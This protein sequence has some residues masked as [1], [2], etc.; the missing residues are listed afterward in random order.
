MRSARVVSMV[1]KMMLG[2]PVP[3]RITLELGVATGAF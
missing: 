1:I 3:G 2:A